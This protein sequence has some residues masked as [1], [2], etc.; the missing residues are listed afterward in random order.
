MTKS[1]LSL[2]AL[3]AITAGFATVNVNADDTAT[4]SP[5]APFTVGASLDLVSQ[6]NW[7]GI[8]VV[9]DPVAQ[10]SATVSAYGFS[11]NWWS[12]FDLT[13][14]DNNEFK[15]NDFSE[16]DI[17]LSYKY[18]YDLLTL[19]GGVIYYYFPSNGTVG[20]DNDTAEVFLGASYDV[21]GLNPTFTAYYDFDEVEGWYLDAGISHTFSLAQ[22]DENL[23]L[24]VAGDLGWMNQDMGAAYFG[25][26]AGSGFSNATVKATLNYQINSHF[27]IAWYVAGA[28]V[29]DGDFQ[30]SLDAAGRDETNFWTGVSLGFAY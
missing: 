14:G 16:H 22:I 17:T 6:Y 25:D 7:R 12:N 28:H 20:D 4:G 11:L 1:F 5:I 27:N 23:S 8:P 3:A 26:N 13:D 10:G 24:V 30:D 2:T 9:D 15:D 19:N 21:F 18:T 29:I